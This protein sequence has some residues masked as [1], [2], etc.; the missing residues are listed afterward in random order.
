MLWWVF[1]NVKSIYSCLLWA[2]YHSG[3]DLSQWKRLCSP[4]YKKQPGLLELKSP[5]TGSFG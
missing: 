4:A 5:M 2:L 3:W 1:L